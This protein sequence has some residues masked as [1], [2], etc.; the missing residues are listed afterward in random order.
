LGAHVQLRANDEAP[1]RLGEY[2]IICRADT[3]VKTTN[4]PQAIEGEILWAGYDDRIALEELAR[5]GAITVDDIINNRQP[6]LKRRLS[7]AN[8]P[9]LHGDKPEAVQVVV[10]REKVR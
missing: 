4:S 10:D 8:Y 6:L 3:R 9:V 2:W 7:A 1:L 5:T